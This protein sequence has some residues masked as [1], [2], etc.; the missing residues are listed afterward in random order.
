MLLNLITPH[1]RENPDD[2]L[3]QRKQVMSWVVLYVLVTWQYSRQHI[4]EFCPK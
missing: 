2:P 1:G 4:T 3:L